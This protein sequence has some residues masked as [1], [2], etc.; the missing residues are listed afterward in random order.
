MQTEPDG[1]TESQTS[2]C[3]IA[4]VAAVVAEVAVG[5]GVIVEGDHVAPVGVDAA[6]VL[7]AA[8]GLAIA[9][10]VPDVVVAEGGNLVHARAAIDKARAGLAVAVPFFG[11]NASA[12]LGEDLSVDLGEEVGGGRLLGGGDAD[13]G[14]AGEESGKRGKELHF[15]CLILIAWATERQVKFKERPL[16]F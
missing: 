7:V 9:E 12:D 3:S 4:T 11:L 6:L 14:G 15:N 8:L 1:S 2:H 10:P 13:G 16:L 5:A